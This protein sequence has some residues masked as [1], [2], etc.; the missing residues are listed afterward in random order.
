M[1][2]SVGCSVTVGTV[3]LD[4]DPKTDIVVDKTISTDVRPKTQVTQ[5]TGSMRSESEAGQ[6]VTATKPE[7]VK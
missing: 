2:F 1:L 7:S 3:N 5:G 6:T 4:G